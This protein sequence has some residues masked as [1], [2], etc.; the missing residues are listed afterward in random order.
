M[1]MSVYQDAAHSLAA[2][3]M[4]ARLIESILV[5]SF[6]AIRTKYGNVLTIGFP[7]SGGTDDKR[8]DC[9]QHVSDKGKWRTD[10]INGTVQLANSIGLSP[11]LPSAAAKTLEAL[12]AYR[13]KNFHV[14]FEWPVKERA[15]FQKRIEREQ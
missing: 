14:G 15:A 7:R 10:L 8:W 2:V 13:N 3:G 11:F 9:H 4:L 12:F 6:D 5:H 1:D